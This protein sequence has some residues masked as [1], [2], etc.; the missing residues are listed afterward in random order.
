M[1]SGPGTHIGFKVQPS[2][3][4]RDASGLFRMIFPDTDK[5]KYTP[6]K[7]QEL[8]IE[9]KNS[10][11][12]VNGMITAEAVNEMQAKGGFESMESVL[13][14][15]KKELDRLYVWI[16]ET[17]AKFFYPGVNVKVTANYGTEF[18]LVSEAELQERF[19]VAK[20]IGLPSEEL[21]NIYRQ[22][23]STKYRG[24]TTKIEKELIL[25]DVDPFPM[26]STEEAIVLKRE[27]VLDDFQLSLKVNFLKF[28]SRF[29]SEN[30][31]II[32]F[33]NQLEYW[34]KIQI[35]ENQLY[36]YNQELIKEK[37]KRANPEG[38]D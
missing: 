19:K 32:D 10:T 12:G 11:V 7:L 38:S 35:I 33:G 2:K 1:F 23:I 26:I 8:E 24:N 21:L 20:E 4:K 28:V 30:G 17:V 37:N 31:S 15:N 9:I 25:I 5:L 36:L 6:E 27:N 14:R 29:E 16:V 18:Y 13:L 34:Q 22:I 3:D